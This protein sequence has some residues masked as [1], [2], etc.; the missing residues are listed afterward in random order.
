MSLLDLL[1]DQLMGEPTAQIGQQLDMDEGSTGKAI[2]AALP[3][4]MAAL[5]SNSTRQDGAASLAGALD[6]DHDG[7]ILDNL[8]GFLSSPDASTG[9]GIL[10][11]ALGGQRPAVE[12]ELGR[13]TGLDLSQ[14]AKLLPILAPIVMG[15]LGRAKRQDSLDVGGLTNMLAGERQH[16][17][18]GSGA[19]LGAFAMLLDSDAD[20]DVADDVAKMGMG[21]L[22]RFL[23]RRR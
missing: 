3:V 9:D 2:A 13:Q 12:E 18:R 21:L 20:G 11:H 16:A 7:S 15:A 22:G 17:E 19:S 14:V 10:K 4:L 1:G 8:T 23:K 6:R 5:A